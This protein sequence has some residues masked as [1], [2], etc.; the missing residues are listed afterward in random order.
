MLACCMQEHTRVSEN[1]SQR[2][3][4][5]P[6]LAYVTPW[7]VISAIMCMFMVFSF[8]RELLY[9]STITISN[10]YSSVGGT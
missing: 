5:N 9:C 4:P 2:N 6:V 10:C 7:C 8:V 1:R 3:F